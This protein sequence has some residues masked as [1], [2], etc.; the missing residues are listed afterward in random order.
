MN[1]ISDVFGVQ[2]NPAE[3]IEG[4]GSRPRNTVKEV[5]VVRL[6]RLP[7]TVESI[8]EWF[9]KA[10]EVKTA[11][12]KERLLSIMGHRRDRLRNTCALETD[13]VE[14]L[15]RILSLGQ[16]ERFRPI[17]VSALPSVS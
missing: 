11:V 9:Q 5:L 10:E 16:A 3:V 1:S 6:R 15:G 14:R 7:F 12:H 13:A 2:Q 8:L 17:A 4:T